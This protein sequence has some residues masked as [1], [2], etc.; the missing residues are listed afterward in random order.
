MNILA[1]L[2]LTL[3]GMLLLGAGV[4]YAHD[5]SEAS[6]A[7]TVAPLVLLARFVGADEG[8][9]GILL[10]LTPFMLLL[11]LFGTNIAERWGY[12]RLMTAGWT[13]RSAMLLAAMT[14]RDSPT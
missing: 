12:R 2:K 13:V 8:D 3:A 1:S 14:G 7:W 5:R 9:I 10:S 4:V 11:Q 6:A